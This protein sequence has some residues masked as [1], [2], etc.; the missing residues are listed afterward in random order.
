MP[1]S[2]LFIGPTLL[3]GIGQVTKKYA[4]LVNGD[5]VEFYNEPGSKTYDYGFGFVL[6]IPEQMNKVDRHLAKCR[7]RFYMTVCET[8]T[9]HPAY[10]LLIERYQTLYVPSEYCLNVFRRQFPCGTWNLLRHTADG[11]PLPPPVTQEYT[12]YTIGNMYDP[13]KNIRMLLEAFLRL[14]I[15]GVRL[16]LKATCREPYVC[17]IPGV[18]VINGLLSDEEIETIHQTCHCYVNCS[19]SE[20]VGMGAVEAA[21]R[22][23]PV[24]ITDYGGLKE[25]IPATPFVV[26][27]GRGLVGQDDFLY[28]KDMVW[29]QPVM[30]SLLEHMRT[31]ARE[32]IVTWDQSLTRKLTGEDVGRSFEDFSIQ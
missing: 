24:I 6:P 23:K 4:N 14:D 32:R 22:D 17:R 20:G 2:W 3:S 26:E 31:C 10:G 7:K 28:T 9:V 11:S 30:S 5:F 27:T 8:E 16:V 21:V 25:Y 12:F 13:R 29:G 15:P 1:P 18:T 19:F